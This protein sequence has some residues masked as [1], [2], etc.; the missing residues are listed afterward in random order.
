[1][2]LSDKVAVIYG[3]G[4]AIGSAVAR[5]FAAEGADVFLT[6]RR[7]APV[8]ALAGDIA[9]AGAAEVDALNER[10]VD[11]HLESVMEHAGR[12]DISL[13]AVGIPNAEILGVC[14]SRHRRGPKRNGDEEAARR[15][16]AGRCAALGDPAASRRM[17][18]R[19]PRPRPGPARPRRR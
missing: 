19:R 14:S 10:A 8:E 4:G 2:M 3:A 16:P 13:D 6:G 11:R 18:P 7:L 5:A 12:V 1:M 9:A 17:P 15:S